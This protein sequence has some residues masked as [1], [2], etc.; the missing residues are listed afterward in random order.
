MTPLREPLPLRVRFA[1]GRPIS[2]MPARRPAQPRDTVEDDRFAGSMRESEVWDAP[3]VRSDDFAA[4]VRSYGQ[5]RDHQMEDAMQPQTQDSELQGWQWLVGTWATEAT[6]PALPGT[7]VNGQA[8]F[9]W[10]E[11]QRFLLQRSHYDHPEIP[12]A[13][14]IS[15]IIDGKQSMHY[16]DP[17]G[18]H[19]V[20]AVDITAH[21]W[22]FWNDAPGFSQRFTGTLSDDGNAIDGQGEL[23]RDGATW[24]RDLAITYRRVG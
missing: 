8:T 22:R 21:T 13:I 10:L 23:S 11:D 24:E 3:K 14:A 16:F 4:R 19:R 1:E 20:F 12:D 7:L 2:E 5:A 18:V 15:G 6:H 9:E 17:R